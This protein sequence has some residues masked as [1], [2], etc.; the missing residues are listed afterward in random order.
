MSLSRFLG[1]ALKAHAD[2]SMALLGC[3]VAVDLKK[4]P[5]L[6]WQWR[7]DAPVASADMTTNSSDDYAAR[8]YLTFSVPPEQLGL[9]TRAKLALARSIYGDQVPDAALN[10]VW[11][12]RH[13]VG[14]LQDNAYT[15]RARMLGLRSGAARAGAWVHERCN[16]LKDFKFAFADVGGQLGGLAVAS[17]TDNTGEKAHAGF[18]DLRFVAH[19]ED[20]AVTGNE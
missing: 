20:C 9:G 16:V 8:I 1:L 15:D 2:K 7:I 6:C 10:C 11:D 14:T 18:A 19:E 5:I 13:P 17:D 4:T 3:P 12:N